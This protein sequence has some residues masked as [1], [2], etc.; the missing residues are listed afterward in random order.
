MW[1]MKYNHNYKDNKNNIHTYIL[2]FVILYVYMGF[3]YIYIWNNTTASF[4]SFFY[5]LHIYIH[6][7]VWTC[8]F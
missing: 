2:L 8:E 1:L 3:I 5:I 7:M 6:S 4:E